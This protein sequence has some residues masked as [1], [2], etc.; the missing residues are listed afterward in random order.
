[1]GSVPLVGRFMDWFVFGK[2]KQMSCETLASFENKMSIKTCK[3]MKVQ[4]VHDVYLTFNSHKA[5]YGL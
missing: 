1:M 5:F 2:E 3:I 4:G